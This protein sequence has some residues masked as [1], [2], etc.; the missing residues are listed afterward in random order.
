MGLNELAAFLEKSNALIRKLEQEGI[1]PSPMLARKSLKALAL[2]A[3][4]SPE[5]AFSADKIIQADGRGITVRIYHPSPAEK[6]PVMLFLHGGGHMC[7]NIDSYDVLCRKM[8]IAA[9][10]VLVSVDYRLAPE[11]PYPA[12]LDDCREVLYRLEEILEGVNSDYETVV[13][14]GDS[15]GG[16]FAATISSEERSSSCPSLA[17][18]ILIYASLDYTKSSESYTKYSKGYLLETDRISWYF[19]NYFQDS[20]DRVKASPLFRTGDNIPPTLII[21]AEYDPLLGDSMRY[22]VRLAEKGV[23]VEYV[24]YPS[25]VHAF[26]FLESLIPEIVSD[27]YSKIGAFFKKVTNYF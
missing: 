9:K 25:M 23:L 10:C 24:E 5:I 12:G 14:A 27:S 21:S 17:G 2:F 15:G 7:G 11:F 6:L 18:Q 1:E 8:C 22:G 20:E 13:I 4:E 19:D 16:A 3:G 26:L